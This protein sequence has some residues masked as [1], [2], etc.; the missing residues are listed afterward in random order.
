MVISL[1]SK[2][3]IYTPRGSRQRLGLLLIPPSYPPH[4]P[5]GAR[6][7]ARGKKKPPAPK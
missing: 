5:L 2:D 6:G 7:G 4:P 3:V 1:K